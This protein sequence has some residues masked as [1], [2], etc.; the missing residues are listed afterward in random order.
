MTL[1]DWG[2]LGEVIGSIA[3]VLSLLYLA[4]QIRQNSRLA[5]AASLQSQADAGIATLSVG[6]F[7]LL[8][9]LDEGTDRGWTSGPIVAL[10][11]ASA[12]A[13]LLFV[14][15][16]RRAGAN[17]VVPRAVLANQPLGRDNRTTLCQAEY[18]CWG[19][20]RAQ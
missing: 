1:D 2:N 4:A 8:L 11:V 15:A 5:R 16:E 3:V 18:T 9:A 20:G 12:V 14:L 13:L 19:S 17:A 7:A 10:F 6:L